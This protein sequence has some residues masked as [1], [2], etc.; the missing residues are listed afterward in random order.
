MHWPISFNPTPLPP[1]SPLPT[2]D[3]YDPSTYQTREILT[4]PNG[5][6]SLNKD[7]SYN[8]ISTW[9]AM[10]EL[11]RQGKCRSI[12]VSNFTV[13]GLEEVCSYAEVKPVVNQVELH[14]YLPQ[15][16]LVQYC[17]DHDIILCAYSPLGSQTVPAEERVISDPVIR[18]IAKER[19]VTEAQVLISWAIRHRG[20]VALPMSSDEGRVRENAVVVELTEG[21]YGRIDGIEKRRRFVNFDEEWGVTEA[22]GHGIFE[23][24]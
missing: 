11:Y 10:E 5:K 13:K 3:T 7:L 2:F 15:P 14:P 9:E 20:T 19:G 18:E 6:P 23:Y 12:G 24:Q 16:E 22:F 21:D 4:L 17:K 1:S 8:H